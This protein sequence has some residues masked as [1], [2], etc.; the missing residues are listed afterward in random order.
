MSTRN[1]FVNFGRLAVAAAC[2]VTATACGGDLLRTGRGPV[3]LVVDKVEG[4]ANGS[5]TASD[6]RSDVR[7]EDGSV[8]NDNVLV[9]LSAVP[10]NP[11][12]TTSPI[13][14]ITLTRYH[15]EFRRAD[16]RNAPG[17]DVPYPF[18]GA[19]SQTI[20]SGQSRVAEF[21]IVRHQAKLEPPLKNLD[22]FGAA[23]R[24]LSGAGFISTIAEITI[25]GRDQNG[26]QVSVAALLD[27]HF[28]DFADQ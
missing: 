25:Y 23:G 19:L 13:Q 26:N 11:A 18:D 22:G 12:Q 28:G 16:G 8:F 4:N 1:S 21:E 20:N 27:V 6:L 14:G 24:S 2:V 7:L 15:V 9:T 3:M 5:S 10:K 17:L